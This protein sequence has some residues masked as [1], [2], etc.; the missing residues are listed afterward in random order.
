M[1]EKIA[2][3]PPF[4]PAN[5][6]RARQG[7]QL[8]LPLMARTG[9]PNGLPTVNPARVENW[10]RF[11]VTKS[12]ATAKDVALATGARAARIH[13]ED[14]GRALLSSGT[15]AAR[16]AALPGLDQKRFLNDLC[17]LVGLPPY[18]PGLRSLDDSDVRA[19]R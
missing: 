4:V 10:R 9:G 17:E 6:S 7:Q 18:A 2:S 13:N 1:A 12:A 11:L 15:L 3:A 5:D 14:E 8:R 19:M 16:F